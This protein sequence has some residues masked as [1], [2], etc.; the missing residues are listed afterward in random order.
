MRKL[1][2]TAAL[3]LCLVPATARAE[4]HMTI[5]DGR[6]S[7]TARNATVQQI[8]AEWAR[9]GQTKIVNAERVPGG[10]LTLQF[11]DVPERDALG[12]ILRSIS[13]YLTAPRPTVVANA[14]S[15][16]RI[17]VMPTS[18]TIAR[19]TGSPLTPAPPQPV[20]ARPDDQ[21]DE[22]FRVAPPA[23]AAPMRP[24]VFNTFPVP[25]NGQPAQ[26]FPTP[27][28]PQNPGQQPAVQTPTAMPVAPPGTATPGVIVQPPQPT[29]PGAPGQP[30]GQQP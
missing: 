28:F 7:L 9:V 17:I 2:F 25:E 27:A 20:M 14:S 12:I 23:N 8:L 16:D 1:I 22:V 6:V 13:G 30:N 15:F 29:Q 10:P 24:P 19:R 26:P 5:S 11:V 18:A 21:A 3:F 4:V